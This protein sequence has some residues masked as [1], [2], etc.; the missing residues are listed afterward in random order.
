VL[1][2][3]D[4]PETTAFFAELGVKLKREETGK[5]FPTTDK[6]ST[7][8][9]ALV[10]ETERFAEIRPG[11][12]VESVQHDGVLFKLDGTFGQMQ[13]KKLILATGG[14]SIPQ[15]GSDGQGYLFAQGLGHT[16]TPRIFPALVPLTVPRNHWIRD[17]KGITLPVTLEL[18]TP[19]G[20]RVES[21]TNSMLC[22][23]FGLSGPAV[24][25][26]SRYY[27][28]AVNVDPG[29]TLTINWLG[30]LDY[31]SF[32]NQLKSERKQSVLQ[33]LR[34]SLP[35]RL[36]RTLVEQAGILSEQTNLPANQL[37]KKVRQSIAKIATR[38]PVPVAG[39]RGF[40][41]AEVTAGG[42]PLKE[43]RLSTMSSRIVPNL[44]FC[45]EILNVDGRI[46]GFNF[47]WAW[48]SG[49]I[50]GNSV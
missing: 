9:N 50:A 41:Y 5:L 4:V 16:I 20:K 36:A 47:Q 25:D 24:L 33:I 31:E 22:T 43:L 46:G 10:Q 32:S 15:T 21:F 7:V 49:Y 44:H 12:R 29:I 18:W 27:L 23:H 8:L 35:D 39:D 30:D 48:A 26:M 11:H 42:V 19:T 28:D 34:Q 3:F 2:H 13:A 1:K 38:F 6:A 37:P 45:G 40:N 17:L 14:K